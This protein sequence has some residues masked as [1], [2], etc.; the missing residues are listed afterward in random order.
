MNSFLQR[1]FRRV[2]RNEADPGGGGISGDPNALV[3]INP[4]GN[5]TATDPDLTAAPVDQYGRPQLL[6]RRVG[7]DGAVW[8]QGGWTADGDPAN[9]IG[10][11]IVVYEPINDQTGNFARIKGSRFGIRRIFNLLDGYAWRQ[12][13]DGQYQDNDNAERTFEVD[14]ATGSLRAAASLGVGPSGSAALIFSG[15]GDPN[16]VVVGNVGD[17]YL[18]RDGAP[19]L[20]L[21]EKES[22]SGSSN[23]WVCVTRGK[24]RDYVSVDSAGNVY[25]ITPNING[26]THN[27]PGNFLIDMN[28]LYPLVLCPGSNPNICA[29]PVNLQIFAP[30]YTVALGLVNVVNTLRLQ[31]CIYSLVGGNWNPTDLPWQVT[32]NY[33][34]TI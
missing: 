7:G 13:L 5:G 2:A 20:I 18:R 4:A 21:Y 24:L 12:D 3:R 19:Y 33:D 11:G 9:V 23:G 29:E 26:V 31:V 34:P 30:L 8:R 1:W 6:D 17:L 22:L 16:G 27:G 10:A 15:I 25:K 14:R 28:P 32:V